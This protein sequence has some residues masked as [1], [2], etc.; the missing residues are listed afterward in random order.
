VSIGP[1]T[2][3]EAREL[4]LEVDVEAEHHHVDGLVAALVADAE[5]AR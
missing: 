2:T 3:A 1:V 5:A 4:G